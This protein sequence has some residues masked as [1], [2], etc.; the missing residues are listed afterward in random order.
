MRDPISLVQ[1]NL[2]T[3]LYHLDRD[4]VSCDNFS[5]FNDEVFIANVDFI[6]N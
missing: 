5:D 3:K 1:I 6:G 4:L 2:L